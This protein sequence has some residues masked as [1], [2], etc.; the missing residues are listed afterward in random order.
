MER[1]MMVD[2]KVKGRRTYCGGAHRQMWAKGLESR[3]RLGRR[4]VAMRDGQPLVA[5]HGPDTRHAP[6]VEPG[7]AT[8]H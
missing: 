3:E 2:A 1:A 8:L 7:H 4:L 5:A 6:E